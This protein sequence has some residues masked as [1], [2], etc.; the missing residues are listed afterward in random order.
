[1]RAEAILGDVSDP[2]FAGRCRHTVSI[3]WGDAAKQRQLVVS[4]TGLQVR[5]MLPRGSFLSDGAVIADDGEHVVVVR[6]P[7][8]PAVVVRFAHNT[9]VDCA[10]RMLVLGYLLG[11]Q[12]APIDVTDEAV[13]A[14]LFTSAEAAEALLADLGIEGA[15]SDVPLAPAGWSR[16][17]GDQ[18]RGHRHN[19]HGE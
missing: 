11:N 10:R 19:H 17:S 1:M 5:I 12:H 18:T 16:T 3:G 8:E 4:D 13:A 6:R 9:G 2:A 14:P 7:P 15:V